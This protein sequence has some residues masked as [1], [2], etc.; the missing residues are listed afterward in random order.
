MP[1]IDDEKMVEALG[2]DGAN[3]ALGIGVGVRGPERG[4]E[5][6]GTFGSK[7]LVEAASIARSAGSKD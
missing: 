4:L 1:L 2:P 7:D 6:L 5:N 3:E